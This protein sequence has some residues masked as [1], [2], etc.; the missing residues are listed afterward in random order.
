MAARR[1]AFG[2]GRFR[3]QI[4]L[5]PNGQSL[6]R[7][8]KDVLT[9][10]CGYLRGARKSR[11]DLVRGIVQGDNDFEILGF[12][13]GNGALGGGHAAGTQNR[14]VADLGDVALEGLVGDGV[15][16]DVHRLAE[17]HVDDIGLIH[18]DFGGDQRHVGD[19]HDDGA[20]LVLE[21]GHDGFADADGE[22][23][24]H[25]VERGEGVV[26]LQ[27]VVEAD[28]VS[29][30]HRDPALG[31][32]ELGGDL[33]ALGAGLGQAGFGLRGRRTAGPRR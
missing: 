31:G 27:Q 28:Q 17:G 32:G 16:G 18:L 9:G 12:L 10:G 22:V 19:G 2:A 23:G 5:L 15:D 8:S 21:A 24:D 4:A 6:N 25:A 30:R 26:L 7:Y 20:V 29:L 11:A 13:A 1:D 14:G 33:L 3:L